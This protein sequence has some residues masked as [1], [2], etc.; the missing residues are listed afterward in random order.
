MQTRIEIPRQPIVIENAV[1]EA[2]FLVFGGVSEAAEALGVVTASIYKVLAQRAVM[3]RSKAEEWEEKTA[4]HGCRIP[5]VELIGMAPW[6]GASRVHPHDP[7]SGDRP[8]GKGNEGRRTTL[9][10]VES[11]RDKARPATTQ[12]PASTL[13]RKPRS[14]KNTAWTARSTERRALQVASG[15]R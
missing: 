6:T 9:A 10:A 4:E 11:T 14:P 13:R 2:V 1:S 7:T 5:A 12:T 3:T 15:W 8:A